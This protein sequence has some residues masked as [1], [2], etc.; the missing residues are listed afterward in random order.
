MNINSAAVILLAL[1]LVMGC[2]TPRQDTV[3]Q[4][5]SKVLLFSYPGFRDE[6]PMRFY[7]KGAYGI[8]IGHGSF[9]AYDPAPT[10][11][12]F[13]ERGGRILVT[14]D[15][16]EF[17]RALER[18]PRSAKVDFY[19]TCTVSLSSAKEKDVLRRCD[20]LG[21]AGACYVMC[22][23]FGSA[24]KPRPWQ[25]KRNAPSGQQRSY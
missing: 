11:E 10:F 18:L 8:V 9:S 25:W 14:Q 2:T 19:D 17:E 7:L 3:A 6:G 22:T 20:E 4:S 1:S 12:L 16:S 15:Q 24:G 13:S 21:I 5:R 23:D